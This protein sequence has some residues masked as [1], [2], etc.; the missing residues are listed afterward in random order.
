MFK[1]LILTITVAI[2][3]SVAY[4]NSEACKKD[5]MANCIAL[6]AITGGYDYVKCQKIDGSHNLC[7]GLPRKKKNAVVCDTAVE[8]ACSNFKNLIP[9]GFCSCRAGRKTSCQVGDFVVEKKP[10]SPFYNPQ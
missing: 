10:S 8:K 6:C 5:V 2:L 1:S 9:K 3:S 7:S 4:G